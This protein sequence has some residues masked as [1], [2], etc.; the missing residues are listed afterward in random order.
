MTTSADIRSDLVDTLRRDLIGPLPSDTALAN[1]ILP[2]RPSRWY[3]TGWLVPT[4]APADQR[5]GTSGDEGDLG[6]GQ[7]GGGNGLDDDGGDPAAPPSAFLPASIGLSV[8]VPEDCDTVIAEA[9]WGDYRPETI[10]G[11]GGPESE[12][13]ASEPLPEIPGEGEPPAESSSTPSGTLRRLIWR[14]TP[15]FTRLAL[16]L[17]DGT[18][19]HPLV[20]TD[21]MALV[22]LVRRA[23][24]GPPTARQRVKAISVFLVNNRHAKPERHRADAAFAFQAMV[25]LTLKDSAFVPRPDPKGLDSQDWDAR[26]GDLHYADV[27]EIAVGHNVAGNWTFDDDRLCRD[28]CTVWMPHAMV[29]RVEPNRH[30]PGTF[31]M[32]TLGSLTNAAA[33]QAALLPLPLAYRNWIAQARGLLGH[34]LPQRR[35]VADELLNRAELAARRIEDGIDAIATD[36]MVFDAF[37]FANRALA[38]SGRRRRA[39]DLR[40]QGAAF[41]PTAGNEPGWYP[42]Q[43]AFLLLNLRGLAEPTHAEREWVELLFFPTGGGKTEAYLGL[44]AF[45]IALRRLRNPGLGGAGLTVLMRYTLRLLTLDQLARAATVVCAL[46]LEREAT[47]AKW[48]DWPIEIALWVGSAATPNRMGAKG[49]AD[50]KRRSARIRTI[51]FKSNRADRPPVPLGFCPW[52]GSDFT[53]G[54]VDLKPDWDNPQRLDLLCTDPTRLCEFHTSNRRPLPI[55]AVDEPIYRRLPAFMIATV[56]KFAAMPWSAE[57]AGFFGGADRHDTTGFYGAA[58]PSRGQ[59]MPSALPPPDLIIQDELHLISGPLGSMVGL[60]E[61]AVD[62]LA[63]RQ[64]GEQRVR[65]KIVASTATVRAAAPHVRAL[66]DRHVVQLFPPP[67]PQR[68]DSFFARSRSVDDPSGRVYLG[69]AAPGGSPK[70]M[71]LRAAV[72]LLSAAQHGFNASGAT[73]DPYMSLL[74]YFNALRELGGA[75]R[76]VEG[77]VGPRLEKYNQHRRVG[78]T[79]AASGLAARQIAFEVTELTSRV[80]TSDVSKAKDRLGVAFP[81]AQ[82]VD[83][84]LA[85]NMISVG[86]DITRLGLMLVSGQPKTVSEY[87]QATSRVGRDDL[88]PGLVVTLLNMNKPR[89]RSHYERF[90]AWHEAF[91][92]GV[93]ATSVTPFSPRALDRALAAVTVAMVRLGLPLMTP[94]RSAAGLA[95]QRPGADQYAQMAGQRAGRHR[96]RQDPALETHVRNSAVALL[97]DWQRI[98]ARVAQA[99]GSLRYDPRSG[100]QLLREM[101]DPVLNSLPVDE[102]RFR[103]ARSLRDVE[104]AVL[105]RLITPT[106]QDLT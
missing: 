44:A 57:V 61:T 98:A 1:E 19:D 17:Q 43:L 71:F 47:P 13:P 28:A 12:D 64:I 7:S 96:P 86:L 66:F 42:F 79:D 32:E 49:V 36:P 14:R 85:T 22:L 8:F 100:R 78:E 63:G 31:G 25:R 88:R 2:S 34:L 87:I 3:L 35:L 93:E 26:V 103:A 104:P 21:G 33:A 82:K 92:R 37:C 27:A 53:T 24:V 73:A 54:S 99:G 68:T 18:T 102:R 11:R 15:G 45:T 97:D 89:D 56:D 58:E 80:S 90:R 105:V 4:G 76:I 67:G 62:A 83:V 9:S 106:G 6:T 5:R 38:A 81:A 95:G 74:C 72:T 70:V 77:E 94:A 51:D 75:R 20:G 30:I 10:E 50:P 48:G 16:P 46:E 59:P 84:A 55:H 65:P 41:D 39:Q 23:E 52:C 69:I 60:Y 101:L 91:Y 40:R 29:P